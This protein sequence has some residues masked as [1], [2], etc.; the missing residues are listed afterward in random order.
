M[1]LNEQNMMSRLVWNRNSLKINNN[2][3]NIS[4]KH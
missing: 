2:I 4:R 1:T 3:E